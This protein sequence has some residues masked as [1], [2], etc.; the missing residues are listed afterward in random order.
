MADVYNRVGDYERAER[1]LG[2]ALVESR[3]VHNRTIEGYALVNRA[4]ALTM[5]AR[6]E[7]AQAM[8][9]DARALAEQIGDRHLLLYARFY[10]VRARATTED[11]PTLAEEA[12]EIAREAEAKFGALAV[13]AYAKA[14]TFFNKAG[15][16]A[17]ALALSD[18]ALELL[19]TLGGVEED[20]AEVF[21]TRAVIL[22][23]AGRMDDAEDV[24]RRGRERLMAVAD[25]ITEPDLKTKLLNGVAA[26]RTLLALSKP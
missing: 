15:D 5:L 26:H 13:I 21:L 23:A 14:A 24:L 6:T 2:E 18:R 3:K 4:Y 25:S 7:E 1:A 12:E 8:L 17:R 20:E 16:A 10:W 9:A 19:E 11:A 22:Q